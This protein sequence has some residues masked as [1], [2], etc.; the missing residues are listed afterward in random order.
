MKK[1]V[2]IAAMI[3]AVTSRNI[4]ARSGPPTSDE[5]Q[6]DGSAIP[7]LRL[8]FRY[9]THDGTAN[10]QMQAETRSAG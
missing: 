7:S 10:L 5:H 6:E 3:K 9:G 1:V 8:S 2:I 4:A